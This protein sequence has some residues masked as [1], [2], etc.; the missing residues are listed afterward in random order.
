MNREPARK[1]CFFFFLRDSFSIYGLVCM[2]LPF[3]LTVVVCHGAD[4]QERR[5]SFTFKDCSVS[6]AIEQV[7][8]ASGIEITTNVALNRKI[9]Q[10]SFNNKKL[11]QVLR[12]L[13]RG[14]NYVMVWH[15]NAQGAD[16]VRISIVEKAVK[17]E[18]KGAATSRQPVTV[19]HTGGSGE[20]KGKTSAPSTVHRTPAARKK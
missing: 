17:K 2:F 20:N 11:S 19:I 16:A 8:R 12:N 4:V 14:S 15:K 1:L 9:A 10:K 13:L 5:W 7:S 18:G 6:D 3:L